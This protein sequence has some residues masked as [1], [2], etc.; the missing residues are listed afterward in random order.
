MVKRSKR[1]TD[2]SSIPQK[3]LF[4]AWVY[5]K[6]SQIPKFQQ[7]FFNPKVKLIHLKINKKV[8]YSKVTKRFDVLS[9]MTNTRY[10]C[11]R[12]VNDDES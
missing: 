10:V 6:R 5:I 7:S 11:S 4:A 9:F 3:S 12:K 8:Q 2:D 1:Q